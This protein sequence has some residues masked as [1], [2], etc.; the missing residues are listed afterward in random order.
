MKV[1][2]CILNVSGDRG[3]HLRAA[4]KCLHDLPSPGSCTSARLRLH[5][6]LEAIVLAPSSGQCLHDLPSPGACT[7]AR[8]R[9]HLA[10]GRV[11]TRLLS[12]VIGF[13]KFCKYIYLIPT[14]VFKTMTGLLNVSTTGNQQLCKIFIGWRKFVA[15][16]L[17]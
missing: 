11:D 3:V 1:Y 9:L 2:S 16:N 17:R 13:T 4:G 8:L 5:L 7:R 10:Q 15:P 12:A 6:A 14:I